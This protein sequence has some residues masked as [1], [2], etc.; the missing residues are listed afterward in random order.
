[1]FLHFIRQKYYEYYFNKKNKKKFSLKN[2][3]IKC[4]NFQRSV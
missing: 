3:I 2:K 4:Q 1:M